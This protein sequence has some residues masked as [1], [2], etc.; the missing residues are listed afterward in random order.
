MGKPIPR[1]VQSESAEKAVVLSV[2]PYA[3]SQELVCSWYL[4][5]IVDNDIHIDMNIIYVRSDNLIVVLLR[6]FSVASALQSTVA[7]V[8]Y[9]S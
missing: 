5:A 2:L 4:V 7:L 9:N 3:F 1:E 8:S 6:Q